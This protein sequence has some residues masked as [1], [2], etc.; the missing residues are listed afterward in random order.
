MALLRTIMSCKLYHRSMP[1]HTRANKKR[2][3]SRLGN[4][5]R[6]TG[7]FLRHP[8]RRNSRTTTVVASPAHPVPSLPLFPPMTKSTIMRTGNHGPS[9]SSRVAGTSRR[10]RSYKGALI[11]IKSRR[12]PQKRTK[13]KSP[14]V[15]LKKRSRSPTGSLSSIKM[16]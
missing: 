6:R 14:T 3:G 4:W 5:M 10:G 12:G 9:L 16:W 2:G 13:S 8:F 11:K 7:S 1:S 15:S